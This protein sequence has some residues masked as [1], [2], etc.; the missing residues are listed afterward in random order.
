MYIVMCD[1]E[2]V[3]EFDLENI[4]YKTTV[5]AIGLFL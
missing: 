4:N 5:L 1:D 2:T 3:F